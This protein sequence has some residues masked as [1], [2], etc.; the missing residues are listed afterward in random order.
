MDVDQIAQ[1]IKELSEGETYDYSVADPSIFARTGFVDASGGQ[2]IAEGFAR[3]GITFMPASNR[4]VD[5]WNLMHQYLRWDVIRP[6]LI[7]FNTCYNSIRTV[8]VLIHDERHG[9][10]VDTRGEDHAGDVTRYFLVSL[11]ERQPMA[12]LNEVQ[13]KLEQIKNRD[14]VQT[15]LSEFYYG[16]R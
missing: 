1:R 16:R 11:H 2:T 15:N 13:K 8:P 7:Y 12:P 3:H 14:S 5:G 9:E 10:D 4:R 6:K